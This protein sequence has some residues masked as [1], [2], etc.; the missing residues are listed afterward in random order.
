MLGDFYTPVSTYL[1]V[2]DLY[3]R[4][5]LLESSD[6]HGGENSRSFIG[7]DPIASVSIG[8]G[9]LTYRMPDGGLIT[10]KLEKTG[11]EG[12]TKVIRD[13]LDCFEVEGEY[14]SYCGIYGYTSFNVVGY[15]E[16]IPVKDETDEEN[17]APDL[18]YILYKYLIVFKGFK[19][20]MTLVELLE[21]G[22]EDHRHQEHPAVLHLPEE[23]H[24][25]ERQDGDGPGVDG[26]DEP[27][28]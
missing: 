23:E 14:S 4:S 27:G 24:D 19:S 2:R 13:F 11:S 9:N 12:I 28:L 20:E 3:A 7:I 21:D 6:Y 1:K 25:R 26:D 10:K 5:F 18:M 8:H 22:E 17:D 16:D 15:L